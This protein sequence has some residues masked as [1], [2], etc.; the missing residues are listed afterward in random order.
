MTLELA[1]LAPGDKVLD[2]G[3]GTGTL[4][5]AAKARA[6]ASGEVHGIDAAPEMIEV[7]RRKAAAQDVDVDFQVGLIEDIPFPDDAFDLVLSSFMLHHLPADLKRAGFVEIHRVL[8]P[9]GRFLAVDLEMPTH[10]L[11][12]S[13]SAL[14]LGREMVHSGIPVLVPELEEAGFCEVSGGR[15]RHRVISY[16]QGAAR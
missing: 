11:F 13:L 15:T 2:V 4:T 12:A 5:I 8:K 14:F 9:D 6:G 1:G 10:H 7:A 3:C 16:L